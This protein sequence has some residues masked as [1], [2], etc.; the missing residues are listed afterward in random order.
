M[1]RAR[2]PLTAGVEA[3]DR[4]RG[5]RSSPGSPSSPARGWPWRTG[6]RRRPRRC[7][8]ARRDQ[9][10]R[11]GGGLRPC[12]AHRRREGRARGSASF[13]V[14]SNAAGRM[15]QDDVVALALR[16]VTRSDAAAEGRIASGAKTTTKPADQSSEI[17]AGPATSPPISRPRI[18]S[19]RMGHRVDVG[20][21]L[22]PAGEGVGRHER[23]AGERERHHHREGDDLHLLRAGRLEPDQHRHPR[24]GQ[25]D[26]HQQRQRARARRPRRCDPEAEHHAEPDAAAR[27]PTPA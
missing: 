1:T 2:R 11:G 6:G 9:G 5:T 18:A 8:A 14:T 15:D 10:H 24:H 13:A 17:M 4:G 22:Q 7:S 20:P 19:A 16:T 26:D 25:R 12:T 23:A 3:G 27:T 21:G